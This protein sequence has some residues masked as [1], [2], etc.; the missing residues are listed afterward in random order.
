MNIS[1]VIPIK[2]YTLQIVTEEGVEGT[3]DVKPYLDLDAFLPLKDYS[4]FTKI[5]NGRYFIE[6]DC[7]A[8][9]SSDTIEA[10]MNVKASEKSKA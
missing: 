7:G 8:D 2:N 3:F 4:E 10:R 5:S 9:L 6:W 1:K